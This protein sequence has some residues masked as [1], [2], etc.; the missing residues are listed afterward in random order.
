MC[1]LVISCSSP[2]YRSRHWQQLKLDYRWSSLLLWCPIWDREKKIKFFCICTWVELCVFSPCVPQVNYGK[3]C[4]ESRKKLQFTVTRGCSPEFVFVPCGSSVAMYA[5][6]T[7]KL[8]TMLKG[9]YNNIDCCEFHPDYQVTQKV[10]GCDCF[11]GQY[12]YSF[13][14]SPFICLCLLC[15]YVLAGLLCTERM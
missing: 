4:N 8:V 1:S 10:L 9:H 6:H 5:L 15:Q 3:V 13:L 11:P 7:G 2:S 14:C 12:I